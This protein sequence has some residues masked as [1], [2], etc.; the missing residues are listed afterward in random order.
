MFQNQPDN[1]KVSDYIKFQIRRNVTNLF[2]QF[3]VVLEDIR[4]NPTDLS[5]VTFERNRKKVLDSGNDAIRE[6]EKNLEKVYI[7]LK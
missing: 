4:S 6:I 7:T 2:K 3:L 5:D 1:E